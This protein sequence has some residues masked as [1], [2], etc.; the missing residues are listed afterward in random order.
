MSYHS[1]LSLVWKEHSMCSSTGSMLVEVQSDILQ[2]GGIHSR[3]TSIASFS[4]NE[5]A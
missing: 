2:Y 5:T 3:S 1:S 4:N